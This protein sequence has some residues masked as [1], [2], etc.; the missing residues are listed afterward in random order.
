MVIINRFYKKKC[1]NYKIIK[2]ITVRNLIWPGY[3]SYNNEYTF[4]YVYFGDG[5]KNS[6][7]E[8]LI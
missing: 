4:G 7:F 8:F 3:I 5:L 1:N 6:D 2:Q